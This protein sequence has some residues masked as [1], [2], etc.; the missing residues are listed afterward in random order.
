M[1]QPLVAGVAGGVGTTTIAVALRALDWD[2]YIEG[3]AVDVL[4]CRSTVHSLGE[5]HRSVGHT[6]YPPI[7]VVVD[8]VPDRARLAAFPSA[9]RARTRMVEPHVAGAVAVPFVP[10]W[11][12][13]RVRQERA[14]AASF[15]WSALVDAGLNWQRQVPV[16]RLC[17][18][19]RGW[20][21]LSGEVTVRVVSPSRRTRFQL[22]LDGFADGSITAL[23]RK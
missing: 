8:D 12:G 2:L 5:A 17:V 14:F 18:R 6:P 16:T 15:C 9:V 4:V 20:S 1:R 10:E 23:R 7:L 21:A 13:D 22:C 19:H 3:T 11:G